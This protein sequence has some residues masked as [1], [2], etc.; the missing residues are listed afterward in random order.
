M[1][2]VTLK[3]NRAFS[4]PTA[5]SVH[6]FIAIGKFKLEL[7]S[8]NVNSGQNL[9][10]LASCDIEILWM[11]LK[12]NGAP[13]HCYFEQCAPFQSQILIQA[14]VTVRTWLIWVLAF[15]TLTSDLAWTSLLSLTITPEM[16]WWYGDG[17]I[18]KIV[19][20]KDG[21]TNGRTD[22]SVLRAA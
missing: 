3:N 10:F 2:Q 5:S 15:V 4:Q 9:R 19:W 17:N 12:D 21:R 11:T 16:S 20:R 8:G 13:L 1:S 6:H 7:Q 18:V 22:W 14:R